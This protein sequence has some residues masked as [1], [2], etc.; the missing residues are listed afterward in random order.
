MLGFAALTSLRLRLRGPRLQLNV[1]FVAGESS[2]A[3]A[4]CVMDR[5]GLLTEAQHTETSGQGASHPRRQKTSWT[6][7]HC[8]SPSRQFAA[9]GGEMSVQ[10][11]GP[12]ASRLRAPPRSLATAPQ[13]ACAEPLDGACGWTRP[14]RGDPT[15]R[16]SMHTDSAA[17][18]R[19]AVSR[20]AS[21]PSFEGAVRTERRFIFTT[22][23][24]SC[25][26]RENDDDA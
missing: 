1:R 24:F 4:S 19:C 3:C 25:A 2:C 11:R 18:R 23:H 5:T 9:G 17:Y 26:V 6:T 8:S 7:V 21:R 15:L 13:R 22:G 16:V 12:R 20:P 14:V 10:L